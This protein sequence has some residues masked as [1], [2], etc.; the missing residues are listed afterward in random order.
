MTTTPEGFAAVIYGAAPI[1][2]ICVEGDLALATRFVTLFP[3]PDK[4]A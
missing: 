4:A 2:T 3:L 1:E